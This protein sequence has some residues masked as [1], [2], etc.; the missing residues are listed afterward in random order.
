MKIGDLVRFNTLVVP[1]ATDKA[2]WVRDAVKNRAPL[3][4]VDMPH[5]IVA[6]VLHNQKLWI[7]NLEF[8]TAEGLA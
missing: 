7:V 1:A 3:L 2:D 5:G 6:Q 8:L 4:V